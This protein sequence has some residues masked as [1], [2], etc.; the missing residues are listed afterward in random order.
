MSVHI[1]VYVYTHILT[2]YLEIN[3]KCILGKMSELLLAN[4]YIFL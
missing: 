4:V 2:A 1:Q 3:L